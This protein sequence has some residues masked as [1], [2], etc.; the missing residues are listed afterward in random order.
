MVV[1]YGTGVMPG[2]TNSLNVPHKLGVIPTM[3]LVNGLEASDNYRFRT[4]TTDLTAIQ[5]TVQSALPS[6][7][8]APFSWLA[9]GFKDE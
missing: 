2:T 8:D 9:I 1:D 7:T 5:F 4:S 3:V 6:S